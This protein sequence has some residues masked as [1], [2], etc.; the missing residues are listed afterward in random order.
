M[1]RLAYLIDTISCDTSGTEKQL[2]EIIERI[3]KKRFI[4][5]LVCLR[6][7]DWMREHS[8]PCPYTVL[9]YNGLLKMSLPRVVNKLRR[10]IVDQKI[11]LVQTFFE[12]SI[13]VAWLATGLGR[14]NVVLLSSRRDMGLGQGNH[15]WYHQL[16]GVLLPFVNKSFDGIVANSYQVR[17]YV[18]KRE[19]T[20]QKKIEVIYNGVSF[21]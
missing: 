3:D 5:H 18:T 13:F 12:D 14:R 16:F 1:I 8:L 15:P 2:L 11:Q 10:V 20:P 19:K 17:E 21:P 6:E 7:S 9:A 4:P